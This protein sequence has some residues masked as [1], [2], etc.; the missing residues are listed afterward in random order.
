MDFH[1]KRTAGFRDVSSSMIQTRSRP[2]YPAV[3]AP[4]W[5]GH[6]VAHPIHGDLAAGEDAFAEAAVRPPDPS[7]RTRVIGGIKRR[8]CPKERLWST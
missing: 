4:A 5:H 8:P 1:C 2:D 6:G 7:S 3:N